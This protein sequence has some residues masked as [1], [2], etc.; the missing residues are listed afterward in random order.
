MPLGSQAKG[1][2]A[3][4]AISGRRS[5]RARAA[6]DFAVPRSPRISTPPIAL[7]MAFRIRARFMRS[8]PTMAVKG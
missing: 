4:T 2:S 1:Q 8:W 5:A 6:V 7:L 3:T